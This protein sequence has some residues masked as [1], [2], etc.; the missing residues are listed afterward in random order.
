MW[1]AFSLHQTELLGEREVHIL[2]VVVYLRSRLVASNSFLSPWTV[3]LQAY[4]S[5][6]F[7]RQDTGRD[8]HFL[9]QGIFLTQES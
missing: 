2:V 3:A 8:C 6:G 7:S 9:L 5:M 4:L 1:G